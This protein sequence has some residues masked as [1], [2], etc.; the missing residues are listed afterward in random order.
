M[1]NASG[2]R[3]ACISYKVLDSVNICTKASQE[4][5]RRPS[6]DG[7]DLL[8]RTLRLKQ[9]PPPTRFCHEHVIKALQDLDNDG[10]STKVRWSYRD[11]LF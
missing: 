4:R 11:N 8:R 9:T 10:S 1:Q 2:E 5:G 6:E 7:W 3:L